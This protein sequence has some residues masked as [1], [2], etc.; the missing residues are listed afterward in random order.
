MPLFS[1]VS[2]DLGRF[3]SLKL[4]FGTGER[5]TGSIDLVW[6]E[7]SMTGSRSLRLMIF[8]ACGEE[9]RLPRSVN[10]LYW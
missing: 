6:C 3:S 1:G 10:G 4:D 5:L 8:L 7:P 2:R 9:F